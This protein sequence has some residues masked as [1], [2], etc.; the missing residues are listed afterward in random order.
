MLQFKV[1]F[2]SLVKIINKT[3]HLLD[4]GHIAVVASIIALVNGGIDVSTY[5]STKSALYSFVNCFRQELSVQNKNVTISM[6]CP[7]LIRTGMFEGFKTRLDFLFKQLE[8]NYVGKRLVKEF[9][10]RKDICYIYEYEAFIFRIINL[11]P[12]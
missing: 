8:P 9:I 7:Y 2:F 11:F 10:Q 1:N 4:N 12:T 6:G 5:S 3:I